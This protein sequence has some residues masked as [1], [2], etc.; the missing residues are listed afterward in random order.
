MEENK[1]NTLILVISGPSGVGKDSL[2]K[3]LIE[4]YPNLFTLL[5]S[6]TTRKPREGEISGKDY[7][8]LSAQEFQQWKDEDRFIESEEVYSGCFY[9][10]PKISDEIINSGKI[11]I[12]DIDI[13]GAISIKKYYKDQASVIFLTPPEPIEDTLKERLEKRGKDSPENII[14]RTSKAREEVEIAKKG[15]DDK[16]VD[17]I[18][19]S[20]KERLFYND[21]CE[22]INKIINQ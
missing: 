21:I 10:S 11:S 9:G 4:K 15:F 3:F 6:A 5:I 16:Y 14:K 19:V 17:Y 2:I 1:L 8:F 22:I 12:S 13:K 20:D 7:H 18:I